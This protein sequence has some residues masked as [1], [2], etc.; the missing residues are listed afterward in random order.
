[1][2]E[3]DFGQG[4]EAFK[5]G[6]YDQAAK[7]F[8]SARQA[9]MNS[10]QLLY[11]LG[12]SYYRLGRYEESRRYFLLLTSDASMAPLA[13]YN[14]AIIADHEGRH[15]DAIG[16]L[17]QV[18]ANTK[19]RKLQYIAQEKLADLRASTG[20]LR[21]LV[22]VKTGYNDN[23][24]VAPTGT[25]A[26]PDGFVE[27]LAHVESLVHGTWHQGLFLAGNFFTRKYLSLDS[28][29][30]DLLQGEIRRPTTCGGIP[31][32]YGGYAY[33][34]TFGGLPYQN[35]FGL[36]TAGKWSLGEH[37]DLHARYRFENIRSLNSA[38]DYLQGQKQQL[39]LER[40][41]GTGKHRLRLR[42]EF[43]INDRADQ[44]GASFSPTRNNLSIRYRISLG[45]HWT[46]RAGLA[47][48][49]SDYPA[50]GVQDRHDHRTGVTLGIS[51]TIGKDLRLRFRYLYTDNES[52]DPTYRYKSNQV[53]AG[54]VVY[55]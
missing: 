10:A 32:W 13:R 7:L 22:S 31:V 49:V 29:S 12:V 4:I 11:N 38:Y 55:F 30:Q 26:G 35:V 14:L 15:D 25:A 21:G 9:G 51:R 42:Y 36:Q 37:V 16:L 18:A 45:T 46:G 5:H 43:E 44:P 20:V 41:S 34:S 3:A 40:I 17:R 24:T 52:T 2:G 50:V 1:M 53:D 39:R 6:D 23:V 47:Y 28:Y 8:E 48:G 19:D 27:V 33:T 54:L